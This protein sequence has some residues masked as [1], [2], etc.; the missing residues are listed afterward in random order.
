MILAIESSC[1]ES[2]IA[3]LDPKLGFYGEWIHSQIELHSE[4]GG[5]VPD[6]ATREHLTHFPSLL[7][8]AK[9]K[10]ANSIPTAIAVT[11]GPGLDLE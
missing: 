4:Y 7:R 8:A 2:A 6:L 1:D 9:K 10:L 11:Q 5:V 3:L